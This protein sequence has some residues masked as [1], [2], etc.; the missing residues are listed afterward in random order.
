MKRNYENIVD[1]KVKNKSFFSEPVVKNFFKSSPENEALLK[2]MIENN[3]EEAAQILDYKFRKYYY[4]YRIISYIS[5]LSYNLSI[6]FD[7]QQRKRKQR[8]QLLLDNP[9]T[10]LF[11]KI[12]NENDLTDEIIYNGNYNLTDYFGDEKLVDALMKLTPK[13]RKIIELIFIH[14]LKQKDI[15]KLLNE[16]P[17]SIAKTKKASLNKLKKLLSR[18]D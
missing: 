1:F 7:I 4:K 5:T 2:R 13:E 9:N 16:T 15:A 3:D 17:Q 12:Y 10:N 8:F 11:S 14:Q 18:S 6:D